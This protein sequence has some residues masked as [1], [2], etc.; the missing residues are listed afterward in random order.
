MRATLAALACGLAACATPPPDAP[1]ISPW[2]HAIEEQRL[3]EDLYQQE[4][5]QRRLE[6]EWEISQRRE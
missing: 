1:E 5:E 3:L 6:L 2:M 4:R